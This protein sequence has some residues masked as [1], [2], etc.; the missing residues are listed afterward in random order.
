[1]TISFY[2][3]AR[4]HQ[5][6]STTP[7]TE[8]GLFHQGLPGYEATP[9]ISLPELAAEFGVAHVFAKDESSRLGLPAFKAL[10]ASWAVNKA[11]SLQEPGAKVTIVTATDGNHGRAI[12]KF[13]RLAGQRAQIFVPLGVHPDAIQAIRDEGAE[14]TVLDAPYDDVVAAAAA[15]AA[16]SPQSILI[17]DTAWEGY[18][19]IPG[20]IVQGY[21]TLFAEIDAQLT[22]HHVAHPSVIASPTGVGSLL[23]AALTHYRN[24]EA[25]EGTAVVSV[26]PEAAACIEPSLRAGTAVSVETGETVMSGLNCGTPSSLAWPLIE[27]GLDAAITISEEQDIVAAYDLNGLGVK[28]GPCGASG[29]AGLRF[30]LT[31]PGSEERRKHLG[32][33]AKSTV[34]FVVTEGSDANPLPPF[35]NR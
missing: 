28:S 11:L 27:N 4:N 14:V 24:A 34:V 16:Q 8:I 32:I 20:W 5:W 21:E 29:L 23:Q 33:T 7:P 13:T 15:A 19:E 35:I 25:P 9:L 3:H 26:E 12:A 22:Q 2:P 1:M 30:A 10:G 31:G 18:E 17:Q 6:R